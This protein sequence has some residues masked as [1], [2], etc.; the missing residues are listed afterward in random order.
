MKFKNYRMSALNESLL[1][2]QDLESDD[3]LDVVGTLPYAD[4]M[5]RNRSIRHR[6]AL[7]DA[8]EDFDDSMKDFI[9][10]TMRR[11][12]N[13]KTTG[14][15]KRM[16]LS[17]SLFEDVKVVSPSVEEE[18]IVVKPTETTTD[19][20][21]E[22]VDFGNPL[23]MGR[24]ACAPLALDYTSAIEGYANHMDGP[25]EARI[26][27]NALNTFRESLED[28]LV[29]VENFNSYWTARYPAMLEVMNRQV[30]LINSVLGDSGVTEA[31]EAPVV[32]KRTRSENEKKWIGDYSSEDLWLAVYDELSATTDNEGAGQQVDKQIKAR[33]GERYEHVYPH[34]DND[35]IIYATKPEEFDFARRVCDHYGVSCDEPKAD[36][37]KTTNGFYKYSMIIHIPEDGLYQ[38]E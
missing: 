19:G 20:L 22:A 38:G 36:K 32:K 25:E 37:N 29:E 2:N 16:K 23:D 30:E 12:I 7:D 33:R 18:E 9:D 26:A 35:I 31:V 13:T 10:D 1:R 28:R 3:G 14:E 4:A 6:K 21:T 15:M 17:E 5:E 34:G 24:G 27:Q 8:M 11:E